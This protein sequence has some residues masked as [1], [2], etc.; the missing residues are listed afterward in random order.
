MVRVTLFNYWFSHAG[1]IATDSGAL[2][3]ILASALI[4]PPA[5]LKI[6]LKRITTLLDFSATYKSVPLYIISTGFPNN[7]L[8]PLIVALILTSPEAFAVLF[9]TKFCHRQQ[10]LRCLHQKVLTHHL[11]SRNLF[12]EYW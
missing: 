9:N 8:G 4:S 5:V 10:R 11:M 6:L 1:K 12:H 3:A 2:N 7:V